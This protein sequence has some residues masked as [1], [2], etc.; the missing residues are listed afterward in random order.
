[1]T[2]TYERDPDQSW[3]VELVRIRRDL[4][5]NEEWHVI[6]DNFCKKIDL[7]TYYKWNCE[8]CAAQRY[9]CKYN[10][11]SKMEG[12]RQSVFEFWIQLSILSKVFL[13]A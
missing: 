2:I 12:S 9:K 5:A 13:N 8:W 3:P 7:G 6:D 11:F 10:L 1:M 4:G